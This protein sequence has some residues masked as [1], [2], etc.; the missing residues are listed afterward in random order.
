MP[1]SSDRNLQAMIYVI[2]PGAGNFEPVN[3]HGE[4]IGYVLEGMIELTIDRRTFL[5]AADDAFTFQSHL[6]HSFRNP[7][8]VTARVLWVN[9]PAT[10]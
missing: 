8:Q 1:H 9:T 4:E 10:F 3:H 7:G 2:P 6:D 5:L